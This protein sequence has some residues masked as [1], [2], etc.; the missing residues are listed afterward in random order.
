MFKDCVVALALRKLT[1]ELDTPTGGALGSGN[2][3]EFEGANSV[4]SSRKLKRID[5]ILFIFALTERISLTAALTN[6][7]NLVFSGMEQHI[8]FYLRGF[9]LAI[10]GEEP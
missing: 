6:W 3:K 5:H 2:V 8:A 9:V 7:K 10:L 1:V 4:I